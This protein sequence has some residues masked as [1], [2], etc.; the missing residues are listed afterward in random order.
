MRTAFK[1]NECRKQPFAGVSFNHR[2]V[3]GSLDHVVVPP[4]TGQALRAKDATS[5]WI[6]SDTAGHAEVRENDSKEE[7]DGALQASPVHWQPDHCT[8]K[9]YGLI[10]CGCAVAYWVDGTNL[11]LVCKITVMVFYFYYYFFFY[12]RW[13]T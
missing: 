13:V 5:W 3:T 7:T 6:P 9:C 11:R 8:Q 12:G 10:Y 2:Q 1:W 4:G